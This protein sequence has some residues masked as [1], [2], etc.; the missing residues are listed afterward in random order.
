V[1]RKID[2]SGAI[3]APQR[4]LAETALSVVVLKRSVSS[5]LSRSA[6]AKAGRTQETNIG[7]RY[8]DFISQ[9]N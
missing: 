5:G 2:T 1:N 8:S 7:K 6:E 9:D 3:L 4:R